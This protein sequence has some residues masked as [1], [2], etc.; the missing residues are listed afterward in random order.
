MVYVCLFSV[1][2]RAGAGQGRGKARQGK[3]ML[4]IYKILGENQ[5]KFFFL[6]YF[7]YRTY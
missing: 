3:D 5:G 7:H 2:N 4:A 6:N 1:T